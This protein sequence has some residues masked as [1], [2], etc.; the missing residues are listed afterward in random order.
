M[1][2]PAMTLT[3][4]MLPLFAANALS[5]EVTPSA[6][7]CSDFKPT[8]AARERFPDLQGACEAV[9][10][11][12]G[13]LYGKFTA[14]VRRV[15]GRSVTLYLPATD[16]TFKVSPGPDAR[17][18]IGNS[19]VRPGDLQ[20]GQEIHIYLSADTFGAVNVEEIALVTETEAVVEY[21]AEPEDTL[22]TTASPWPAL[23]LASIALIGAGLFLRRRQL[24]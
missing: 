13:N 4:L 15:T 23:G 3:L 12:D 8:D 21:P 14:V 9:V 16:R 5:A 20:R 1:K 7:S 11:R 6:L 22:P 18:L 19:K 10:E 17:V 24:S 2:N